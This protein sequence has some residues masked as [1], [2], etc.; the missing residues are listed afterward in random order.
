M[1]NLRFLAEW[2]LQRVAR[3]LTLFGY[4]TEVVHK[5]TKEEIYKCASKRCKILT[6]SKRWEKTF[7]NLKVDYLILPNT[8]DWTTQLCMVLRHFNLKPSL[9]LNYCPHCLGKLK[10]VSPEEVRD[11]I[12]YYSYRCGKNFTICPD[13]GRVYWEGGHKKL[14]D[15]ALLRIKERCK[16]LFGEL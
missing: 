15:K 2:H 11:K 7:K 9:E 6:T 4:P 3:W 5:L 16:D 10:P 14:M 13:C 1:K 8:E 12:P